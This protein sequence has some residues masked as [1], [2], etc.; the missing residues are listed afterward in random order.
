METMRK[1][2]LLVLIVSTFVAGRARG[3][4]K[5][6]KNQIDRVVRAAVE[7]K[8]IPGVVAM[9]ATGAGVIYQG[10][11]GN[12]DVRRSAPMTAD[13]IFRIASMTK[14]VTSVAVMQLVERGKVQLDEP[15][16]N[17][18]PELSRVQV[19][20]QTKLRPPKTP[21]TVRQLLSHTSGFAYEFF[22]RELRDYA[23]AGSV[24][25]MLAG[26]DG[27]LR[28]PILFDPGS[29]WEY[30]ISI[31]WLGK[32]VERI[33]GQ[34]LE[35]YFRQHIFEPLGMMDTFFNIPENK[36]L[37]LVTVHQRKSDGSLEET[38]SQ[39]IKPAQF[40]SGGG[41]LHSTAGDYLK[42]TR[43]LLAGG[44]LGKTRILKPETVALMG[45]NQIGDL[46]LRAFRSLVP[47][48]A[49]DSVQMPGSLDKFGL[50]FAI[51]T[52][53]VDQGR[54]AGS[55][56]WAGIY[57]T[58]FWIDP[59][60]KTCTVIMMQVLPFLDEAPKAVLEEFERA[61]YAGKN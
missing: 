20:E 48:L 34:S 1:R 12:R 8:K 50:G 27:F 49:R 31:D 60:R 32:L 14:P 30:G 29:K 54:A 43:M 11:F 26:G 25:G 35:D 44:Q 56:A 24:P 13:T 45:Q 37:R 53:P 21:I 15:A 4:P 6:G 61:V 51:N 9:A 36:Q 38:P 59:G 57:N 42:F 52:K 41:G 58:F 28:A 23:A 10:A 5:S 17:Y 47:Q 55:L 2:V 3:A 22:N 39:P 19:L 33:S 46:T 40:F 18:L 16:G 7:Q